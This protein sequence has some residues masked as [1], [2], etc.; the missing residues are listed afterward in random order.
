MQDL[1][2][3]ALLADRDFDDERVPA[4]LDELGKE[5]L[6]DRTPFFGALVALAEDERASVE[7]RRRALI[8]L[9]GA[10]GLLTIET[11]AACLDNPALADDAIRV[12]VHVAK[13][14][15][16]RWA[17]VVFHERAEVRALGL[18]LSRAGEAPRDW[19]LLLVA[20]PAH[21]D[22]ILAD[23]EKG[24]LQPPGGL[25]LLIDLARSK[26]LTAA[27]AWGVLRAKPA[28]LA[29]SQDKLRLRTAALAN[30][31]LSTVNTEPDFSMI[32]GV[33][34]ELD[35]LL[36]VIPDDPPE[37]TEKTMHSAATMSSQLAASAWL[38]IRARGTTPSRLHL[39]A[40]F[41]PAS[42]LSPK[43]DRADV[44]TGAALWHRWNVHYQSAVV[45]PL[46]AA[47]ALR[48]NGGLDL[49]VATGIIRLCDKK[50]FHRLVDAVTPELL[51]MALIEE[52]IEDVVALLSL[53][54]E[55][56][57]GRT[58]TLGL[59]PAVDERRTR[60]AIL[61]AM[62]VKGP[63]HLFPF[64]AGN[65][66]FRAAMQDPQ[67]R[68]LDAERS[69]AF[70]HAVMATCGSDVI[71]R[72]LDELCSVGAASCTLAR[73][74]LIEASLSLETDAFVDGMLALEQRLLPEER[75]RLAMLLST[76]EPGALALGKELARAARRAQ[77][78]D[79]RLVGWA[80]ERTPAP[81]ATT[82]SARQR[83]GVAYKS[84]PSAPSVEACVLLL[85]SMDPAGAT[86]E[87][88][89]KVSS[90]SPAFLEELDRAMVRAYGPT[91][92]LL[93]PLGH[94][95]LWRWDTHALA[96]FDTG[97]EDHP[98]L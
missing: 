46:L 67:I 16:A 64:I 32:D 33:V 47:R 25:A 69:A 42:F 91:S 95:L 26:M 54:D 4:L 18:E 45:E 74:T 97:L 19:D 75:G 63:T 15:A 8:A 85:G 48:E 94:A 1:L 96:H 41:H 13:S 44:R 72:V 7:L 65:T 79:E 76:V 2:L 55:N 62:V 37:P 88:F 56:D 35:D 81:I 61:A 50:P 71:P 86:D 43:L 57:E 60:G 30:R 68:S 93:S 28:L 77:H 6:R 36:R 89:A 59:V 14:E 40:L 27:A 20:D 38:D 5:T 82:S 58:S 39:L 12:L 73:V 49:Y 23:A 3:F 24:T 21:K 9:R 70:A 98:S 90:E 10:T 52:P 53:H 29:G 11:A 34:D 83:Q 84:P 31:F 80:A 17:H 22:G 51:T 66:Q 78:A 92:E 87:A